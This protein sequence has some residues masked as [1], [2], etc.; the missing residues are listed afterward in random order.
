[1]RTRRLDGW[2]LKK[3]DLEQDKSVL[4]NIHE[5]L[6]HALEVLA[7]L[8]KAEGIKYWLD[9][10][11][12]LGAV[13]DNDFIPWDDDIDIAI[14]EADKARFLELVNTR[15]SDELETFTAENCVGLLTPIKL[16]LR[17]TR[18]RERAFHERGIQAEDFGLSI[19]VFTLA[20]TN[21]QKLFLRDKISIFLFQKKWLSVNMKLRYAAREVTLPRLVFWTLMKI[22]PFSILKKL[23]SNSIRRVYSRSETD[24]MLRYTADCPFYNNAIAKEVIFSTKLIKFRGKYFNSPNYEKELLCA[25]Y[26]DSYIEPPQENHRKSHTLVLKVD[27]TSPFYNFF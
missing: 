16:T 12:L 5:A 24:E 22:I 13:R 11:T 20:P 1:M 8:L 2:L 14:L 19:D 9:F 23:H 18:V 4:N 3:F 10:G 21:I 15:L 7:S 26:G 25:H 27:S 6:F 17:G